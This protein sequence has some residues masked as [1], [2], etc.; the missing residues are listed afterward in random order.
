MPFR[1]RHVVE[2]T[3]GDDE[4]N[5]TPA[6]LRSAVS[7]L[8]GRLHEDGI[9]SIDGA[10]VNEIDGKIGL[11]RVPSGISSIEIFEPDLFPSDLR[12]IHLGGTSF[13][14]AVTWQDTFGMLKRK[15]E[16]KSGIPPCAQQLSIGNKSLQDA[17]K[18]CHVTASTKANVYLM[19]MSED[20]FTI[21]IRTLTGK[22]SAIQVGMADTVL[23]L[24]K[25]IQ[26]KEGTLPHELRLMTK[27]QQMQ[28]A[29]MLGSYGVNAGSMVHTVS[30]LRGCGCGC[31]QNRYPYVE[32]DV[33]VDNAAK[34]GGLERK[35]DRTSESSVAVRY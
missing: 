32:V 10:V 7:Y 13:Q 24:K 3:V 15:I 26:D 22:T 35:E 29:A 27:G 30:T 4:Y 25:K 34:I 19:D 8:S 12:I 17:Q 33:K 21:M 31:G 11:S 6:S 2:Y 18:L 20:K 1:V 14:V 16:L 28:D 9:V 23:Q 5:T